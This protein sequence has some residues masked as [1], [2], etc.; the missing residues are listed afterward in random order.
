MDRSGTLT[1]PSSK[2]TRMK[3]GSCRRL[4]HLALLVALTIAAASF[5]PAAGAKTCQ[6]NVGPTAVNVRNISCKKA[7][8]KVVKPY[9]QA[10]FSNTS[11]VE[12]RRG[13]KR[14]DRA[15][16]VCHFRVNGFKCTATNKTKWKIRVACVRKANGQKQKVAWTY[17]RR[18]G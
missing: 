7:E 13:C 16:N 12:W 15:G 14:M 8:K 10:L 2:R 9:F 18:I 3:T 4:P 11:P 5:A 1:Q 6:S 17:D